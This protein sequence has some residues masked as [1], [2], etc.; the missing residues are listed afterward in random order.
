MISYRDV[1]GPSL[2]CVHGIKHAV[3]LVFPQGDL[4]P[5]NP[6]LPVDVPVWLALN[7]KQRQKCRIVPPEWMDAGKTKNFQINRTVFLI[8]VCRSV[9]RECISHDVTDRQEIINDVCQKVI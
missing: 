7:L 8:R 6:G 4:G 5:F 2:V 9:V 1:T 3:F